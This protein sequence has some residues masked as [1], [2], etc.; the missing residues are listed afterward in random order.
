MANS[1]KLGLASVM[2]TL[3]QVIEVDGEG[4]YLGKIKQLSISI[5]D[6]P[7]RLL[8]STPVLLYFPEGAAWN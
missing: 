8:V 1:V 3:N 6:L 4:D 7:P 2:P 5:C